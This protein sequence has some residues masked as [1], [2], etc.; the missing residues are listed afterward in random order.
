[1]TCKE[2]EE[3]SGAFVLGA[4]TAEEREAAH[5]HLRE[6]KACARLYQELRSVVALLPLSVP[7][8]EP[9]S[10]LEARIFAAIRK[11]SKIAAR[12]TDQLPT[13]ASA[14][15]Q[16]RKRKVT[17]VASR[18]IM[19]VAAVLLLTLLVGMSLLTY[20]LEQQL[21]SVN[22]RVA[23][24]G[25]QLANTQQQL[26]S[27]SP[28]QLASI[29]GTPTVKGVNGELYYLPQQNVTILVMHGLPRLQGNQVYQ[30]W[31]LSTRGKKI[32]S[33]KSVGLLTLEGN[34]A[35]VSFP[36]KVTSYNTA[37]VS[38]EPGPTPS[39]NVPSGPVIASGSVHD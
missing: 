26:V 25:Q 15:R 10:S 16:R 31:L 3:L 30:G 1:M 9:S 32:T 20:S 8:V 14:R 27:V 12:S 4:V 7:Q 33:I 28:H 34:T 23:N 11:D 21:T 19:G 37:A 38:R 5:S 39:L 36:G 24:I 35:I 13:I 18:F 6:C 2:F 22:Q 29:V 17:G